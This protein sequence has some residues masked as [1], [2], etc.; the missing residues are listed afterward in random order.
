M[1]ESADDR[2]LGQI[3]YHGY[4]IT[5]G[6]GRLFAPML[7]ALMGLWLLFAFAFSLDFRCNIEQSSG[8][9]VGPPLAAAA[10]CE[11]SSGRKPGEL[12][13]CVLPTGQFE[14]PSKI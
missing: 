3:R 11:P 2:P 5:R 13:R 14:Q 10:S 4:R 8:N 1:P 7:A 9:A 6:D 12:L